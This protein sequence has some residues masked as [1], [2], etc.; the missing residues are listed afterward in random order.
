VAAN[1]APWRG[2]KPRRVFDIDQLEQLGAR[3]EALKRKSL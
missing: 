3:M 1:A 2:V